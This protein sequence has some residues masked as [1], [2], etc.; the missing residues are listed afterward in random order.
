MNGDLRRQPI[1]AVPAQRRAPHTSARKV[2]AAEI[3]NA[4]PLPAALFDHERCLIQ[5]NPAM[6]AMLRPSDDGQSLTLEDVAVTFSSDTHASASAGA[7]SV[8]VTL[9][10]LES[11]GYIGILPTTD[12]SRLALPPHQI[13][14]LTGLPDRSVLDPLFK[15]VRSDAKEGTCA[16]LLIDLD[17]FKNVNDT[18]GHPAGDALLMQVVERLKSTIREEDTLL[19][20]GGDEFAL[21]QVGACQPDAA[22]GLAKRLVDL[23]SRTYL[24]DG[25]VVNIGA[26]VGIAIEEVKDA[27]AARLLKAADLALYYAKENGRGQHHFFDPAMEEA[28]SLRRE[29][30]GDMRKAIVLRQFE[31]HYQPLADL[32]DETITGVEALV[33]WKHPTK[34]MIQPDDFIP[35]AEE[36][37]LIIKIGELVLQKACQFAATWPD[38]QLIAVNISAVQIE[39]EGFVETVKD[40]LT[41]SGLAPNRLELE[42]TESLMVNN[43]QGALGVLEQLKAIG[44]RIVMDDFGTGYSSLSYLQSFAFDKVKIDR[45]FI[46]NLNENDETANIVKAIVDLGMTLGMKTTAEGVETKAQLDQLKAKGCDEVQGYHISHPLAESD[47]T[48]LLN[49]APKP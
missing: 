29:L 13:D 27:D 36:T 24:L 47:L 8:D 5:V 9:H 37:G 38:E 20:L 42:V 41:R 28:A 14:T 35:L 4:L 32:S 7:G 17:R 12:D 43:M 16:L 11:A 48:A 34:G 3:I 19:R 22:D 46:A 30:E 10:P 39:T 26:S 31:V 33:R 6:F 2:C 49:S 18:L 21:I 23:V 45:S 40:V 44:V 1:A 15:T 25:Q